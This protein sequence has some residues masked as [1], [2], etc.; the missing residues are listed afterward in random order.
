MK[1]CA[2]LTRLEHQVTLVTKRGPAATEPGV[3]DA[4]AF[5]GVEPTFRLLELR[6]PP[7]T[8]GG[9]LFAW[10]VRRLIRR[11]PPDSLLYCRDLAAAWLGA[12]LGRTVVFEAHGLPSSGFAGFLLR[13]LLTGG[14]LRRLV[15]ISAALRDELD[16]L[17]LLA[18]GL[19]VVTAPDAADPRP[20]GPAAAPPRDQTG[21][22]RIGYVGSFHPGKGADLVLRLAGRLPEHE[23]RL[24]GGDERDLE[25]LRAG[26]PPPNAHLDGFAPPA[27]VPEILDRCD[28]LLMPYGRRVLG[29]ARAADIAPWMSPLKMFEYMAAGKPIVS[30]DLPVLREVLENGR[31]ALLVPADDLEAWVAAIRR[32]A[33]DPELARRLGRAALELAGCHTWDARA[34][35]VLDGL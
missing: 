16:R 33:A 25:R 29:A 4:Y 17:G 18:A 32:L 1:M 10:E 20:E 13:R 26:S 30:S 3:E 35:E 31:N 2:A 14:R 5:Y 21:G 22:L 12:R 27:R 8:G 6:R 23:F 19:D 15:V 7:R 28:L 11:A 34:A 24:T 9:L